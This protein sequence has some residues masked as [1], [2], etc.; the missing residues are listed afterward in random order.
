LL[1][2]VAHDGGHSDQL[3]GF[4]LYWGDRE[5]HGDCGTIFA[6]RWH[7]KEI[8]VRV[9]A[10]TSLDDLIVAI[11]MPLPQ[12]LRNNEIK[13]LFERLLPR[14]AEQPLGTRIPKANDAVPIRGNDCIGATC[15][16]A[17]ATTSEMFTVRAFSSAAI[18][19]KSLA[20]LAVVKSESRYPP[21][22]L[23]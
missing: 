1:G 13:R 14:K 23:N 22:T 18:L 7:G 3:S 19:M 12:S 8:T 11:P 10:V 16:R 5:L 17:S 6:D 9:T 21:P 2:D 20:Q 15:N 4:V